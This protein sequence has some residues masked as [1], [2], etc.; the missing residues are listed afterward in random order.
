MVAYLP[1]KK[2]NIAIPDEEHFSLIDDKPGP[3]YFCF[4]YSKINIDINDII[5]KIENGTG[6]FTERIET[7]LVN[8]RVD[9]AKITLIDGNEIKFTA[10]SD[11][12]MVVPILVV[13]PK[14]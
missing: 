1:Y 6:S 8:I 13:I 7:A 2:N 9:N 3:A 10:K 12:K 4:L 11:D 14:P 5:S